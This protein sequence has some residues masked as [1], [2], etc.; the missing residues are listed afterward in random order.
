MKFPSVLIT[1]ASSTFST[2]LL[3]SEKSGVPVGWF[4]GAGAGAGAPG[5]APGTFWGG[6]GKGK[7]V[8]N[9]SIRRC[10]NFSRNLTN[11]FVFSKGLA[12]PQNPL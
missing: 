11:C 4:P 12:S 5:I 10:S 9:L 3:V 8:G 2:W 6:D 1:S 7:G